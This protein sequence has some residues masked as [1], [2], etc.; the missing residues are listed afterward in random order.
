VIE[1]ENANVR[2]AAVDAS[3]ALEQLQNVLRVAFP[4][5]CFACATMRGV[6][7]AI[8]PVITVMIDAAALSAPARPHTRASDT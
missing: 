5:S 6:A 3:A 8:L 7:L 1:L 2:L 4:V